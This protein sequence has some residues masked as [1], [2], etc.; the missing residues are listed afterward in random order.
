M[1]GNFHSWQNQEKIIYVVED[2]MIYFVLNVGSFWYGKVERP[3]NGIKKFCFTSGSRWFLL[4]KT[5]HPGIINSDSFS[6]I[7][8]LIDS[9]LL[10]DIICELK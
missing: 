9:R 5:S 3:I 6:V 7:V 10:Y 1:A 8:E 4:K 2:Q